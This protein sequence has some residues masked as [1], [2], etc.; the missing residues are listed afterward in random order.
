[1][2]DTAI[3][4]LIATAS[5]SVQFQT[6]TETVDSGGARIPGTLGNLGSAMTAWVQPASS[7]T[8]ESYG[9]REIRVTHSIYL[10]ADPGVG[11]GDVAVYDGR[12]FLVR[13][14]RNVS[15]LD[16]L[17]KVDVEEQL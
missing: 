3:V 14:S 17:W 16:R 11:E 10:S 13:G 6:Q 9:K 4:N 15:E 1:M 8:L 12:S 7:D 2:P 5:H